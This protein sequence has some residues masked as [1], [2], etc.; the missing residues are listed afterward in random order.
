MGFICGSNGVSSQDSILISKYLDEYNKA[1]KYAE[2]DEIELI[3]AEDFIP[4]EYLDLY[5][6][7]KEY[8]SITINLTKHTC[9]Y[10]LFDGDI[11]REIGLISAVSETTGER[12]L[13]ACVEGKYLDDFGYVK[14]DFLIVDSVHLTHRLFSSIGKEVPSFEELKTMISGDEKTWNIYEKGITC[15]VNQCEQQKTIYKVMKYKP[16]SLAELSAFIAAIRPGFASSLK[17][18]LGREDYS[19]G[20]EVIDNLLKDTSHFMLYQESIMKVL[21][22]LEMKMNDTYGVIKSISKK[23]YKDHPEKLA[24]LKSGLISSWKDKISNVNNFD[25]VW[26]I[27][28]DSAFYAFNSPHAYSM[29]GDSAYQAWFKAHHPLIFYEEA[30]NH[31]QEKNKKAKIESLIKESLKFYGLKLGSYKFGKD[32]RKVTIDKNE[33]IIYPNLSSVKNFGEKVVSELY[34]IGLEQ[35]DSFIDV[36]NKISETSINGSRVDDLIKLNYFEEFGEVNYLL[37][38]KKYYELIYSAKVLKKSKIKENNLDESIISKYGHETA[39]QYNQLETKKILNEMINNIT[40]EPLTLKEKLDI[41]QDI[42]G[43]V[44][45]KDKNISKR[46]YYVTGLEVLK[47]IT[48]ISLYEIYTGKTREV[49]MW[50]NTF[51]RNPFSQ[52]DIVY[53]IVLEKKN[54][55]EPTG[56]INPVTGKKIYVDIPDK[57]EFW[58]GKYKIMD[59]IKQ[60]EGA[61]E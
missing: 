61:D 52:K 54:K 43:I 25:T 2:E 50:T 3:H 40:C 34:A 1:L 5:N 42:L 14:D 26:K 58:L 21:S 53:I 6:K 33:L 17:M 56:E 20:E 4:E 47:S 45:A 23:K 15:C 19:T 31:Y 32:N 46:I 28:E 49:K 24:E 37:S 36:L 30:I 16:K 27:I 51:N 44:T 60:D 12:T 7:S 22:F 57:F 38:V 11:R 13:V 48:N 9:G 29:G 8:Q 18:F 41:E 59:D 55:K 39:S 10:L 35:Y